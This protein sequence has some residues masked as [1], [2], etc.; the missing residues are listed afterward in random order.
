VGEK[1]RGTPPLPSAFGYARA[2]TR[3]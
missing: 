1:G 2:V 3:K